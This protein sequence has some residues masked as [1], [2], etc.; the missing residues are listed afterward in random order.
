MDG[1]REYLLKVQSYTAALKFGVLVVQT[2]L[3]VASTVLA[4]V[5]CSVTGNV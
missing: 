1:S 4:Q 2:Y 5:T 3:L